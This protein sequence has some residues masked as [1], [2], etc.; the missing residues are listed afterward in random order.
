MLNGMDFF[1][2]V[3]TPRLLPVA[4]RRLF[5]WKAARHDLECRHLISAWSSGRLPRVPM[6]ELFPGI[7]NTDVILRKAESR[8]VGWSLD[9]QELVH[10]LSIVKLTRPKLVLEIGTYDG[11]TALNIA[12]NLDPGAEVRTLDLPQEL[13]AEAV[14]AKGISNAWVTNLTGEKFTAE[15]EAA[16]IRQLWGDS[17]LADWNSFGSL[18]DLILIDGSHDYPYVRN[19]GLKALQS[20]RPGGTIL[21]H[22]YGQ[23]VD[24][25]RAVDELA[26]DHDIRAIKGTRFA[27][28]RVPALPGSS[29]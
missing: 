22:D 21:W 16:R 17:L 23:C 27:C 12:A 26:A 20:I 6:A 14:R 3:T 8:T 7:A 10:L 19:D 9:L 1:E 15:P 11:F 25:S 5:P 29:S 28:L 2:T 18:F 13:D 24:V 4:V